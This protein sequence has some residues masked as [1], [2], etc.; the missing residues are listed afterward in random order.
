MKLRVLIV[1]KKYNKKINELRNQT[2]DLNTLLK[3][4]YKECYYRNFCNSF[5]K[6]LDDIKIIAIKFQ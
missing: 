4:N 5:N 1:V 2:L 6:I 3:T